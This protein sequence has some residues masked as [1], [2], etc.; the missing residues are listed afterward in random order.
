MFVIAFV[1]R[2]LL[3]GILLIFEQSISSFSLHRNSRYPP[4]ENTFV[5]LLSSWSNYPAGD[6]YNGVSILVVH[7]FAYGRANLHKGMD[8]IVD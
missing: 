6:Q 3:I 1:L 4:S 7:R 5:H 2:A 8:V